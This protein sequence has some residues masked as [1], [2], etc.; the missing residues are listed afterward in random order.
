MGRAIFITREE[1]A[2]AIS[3]LREEF[4]KQQTAVVA[5]VV[6]SCAKAWLPGYAAHVGRSISCIELFAETTTD[7]Q[8]ADHLN[9]LVEALREIQPT[10][11][12]QVESRILAH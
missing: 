12:D 7:E 5:T 8:V 10:N 2:A 6:W 4:Q 3:E 1:L 9:D 11:E